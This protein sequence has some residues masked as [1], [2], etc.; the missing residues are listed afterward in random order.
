MTA[1]IALGTAPSVPLSTLWTM[2]LHYRTHH[3][4]SLEL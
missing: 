4:S 3:E 2:Q 1:P